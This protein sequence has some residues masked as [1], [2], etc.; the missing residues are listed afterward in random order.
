MRKSK[1]KQLVSCQVQCRQ[2]SQH[3]RAPVG[4]ALCPGASAGASAEPASEPPELI[5]VFPHPHHVRQ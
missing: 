4:A 2:V 3:F 1:G 5:C